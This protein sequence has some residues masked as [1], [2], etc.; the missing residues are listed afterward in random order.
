ML[1]FALVVLCYLSLVNL[2]MCNVLLFFSNNSK[3]LPFS[4]KRDANSIDFIC[5]GLKKLCSYLSVL[6]PLLLV[7]PGALDLRFCI[8]LY[9]LDSQDNKE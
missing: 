3:G 8:S 4:Y 9:Y 2:G 1:T 5:L 7:S 6:L